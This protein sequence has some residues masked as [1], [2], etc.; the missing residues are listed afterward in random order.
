M[1][2]I[3]FVGPT[4]QSQSVVIDASRSVNFYPEINQQDS[5][6][7]ISLVGT[8][9]TDLWATVGTGIIRGKHVFNSLLFVVSG[10]KLYSVTTG[11]VATERGTLSTSTG[12]VSMQDNGIASAGVGGNQL[13]IVDG[14]SGYIYNVSTLAFVTITDPDFPTN[15]TTVA[16]LDGYFIVSKSGSMTFHVSDLYNGLSWNALAT[17]NIVGS[18]DPIQ[19]VVAANQQLWFLKS[20]T[21]EIWYNNS[22]ATSVGSPFSRISGSVY[23]FGIAA[24]FS[25]AKGGGG[26]FFLANVRVG[27]IGSLIGVVK[28]VGGSPTFITPT[29][30]AYR[31]KQLSTVSDAIGY[32]YVDVG[33]AFY[34]ITFP[35][36][37]A[38]Y[39]YDD[40]SQMWHERSYYKGSA[41]AVG[42]HIGNCYAWFAGK[43]LIGDYRANGKIYEMSQNHYDDDG[44]PLVAVRTAQHIYDKEKLRRQFFHK[45]QVD[46]ETG[47][48]TVAV[49]NP[50]AALS[51]S[52]DGGRTFSSDYDAAMGAIGQYKTRMVWRRLGSSYDR[53]FRLTISDAVKRVILGAYA[54][55]T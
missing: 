44:Q 42:R 8:P 29:A 1:G 28:S 36:A 4:Y 53:V 26:L 48:G 27:D 11:G 34:V 43:H 21:S 51:W 16:Y 23:D 19:A 37:D 35:T 5:K 40:T 3:P 17:A 10:N 30:I 24:P 54:E 49:T 6:S 9:G 41:Y 20:V 25:I 32:C 55:I 46:A 2:Q 38:T 13:I 7:I 50:V 52:D 31:M 45:V 22:V 12:P 15:P 47:I 18:P 33:H 39:V 14:T